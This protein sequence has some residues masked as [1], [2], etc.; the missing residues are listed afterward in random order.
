MTT[1][2]RQCSLLRGV[3]VGGHNRVAM[4]RL[5]EL[6]EGLGCTDV[7]T[8]VQ[9]GNVAFS[10]P[11]DPRGISAKV[12]KAIRHEFALEIRVLGRTHRELEKIVATDAFAGADPA[13]RHVVFLSDALA[14][15]AADTLRDAAAGREEVVVA[16]REIHL[17][18]P[19]GMGRTKLSGAL[20][21]RRQHVIATA[22][23]WRTVT[24]LRDLTA[25]SR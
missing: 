8:Y 17:L 25:S 16:G 4:A 15:E 1:A 20:I 12:E 11:L 22:R 5:S 2:A 21:E 14:A 13:S 3:N 9:S 23:N 18:L 10:S 19:D 6:Y 7:E 24:R